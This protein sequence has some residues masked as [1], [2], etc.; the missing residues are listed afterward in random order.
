MRDKDFNVWSQPTPK[1]T[2]QSLN[3]PV[4]IFEAGNTKENLERQIG[5]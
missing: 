5:L 4:S 3:L 1:E 2:H